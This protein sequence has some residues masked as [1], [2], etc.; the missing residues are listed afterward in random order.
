MC[1]QLNQSSV[2]LWKERE[3]LQ[4]LFVLTAQ[5]INHG[6]LLERAALSRQSER[7]AC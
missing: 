2:C 5:K 7:V 1:V 3:G 4:S 6:G